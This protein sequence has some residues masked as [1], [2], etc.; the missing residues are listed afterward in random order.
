MELL[1]RTPIERIIRRLERHPTVVVTA[2]TLSLRFAKDYQRV[3]S[4]EIDGA[5]FKRRG[6]T[7]VGSISG[8]MAGAAAGALAGTAFAPGLGTILGAFTGSLVGDEA[9]SRLGRAAVEHAEVRFGRRRRPEA[10]LAREAP[11]SEPADGP[12]RKL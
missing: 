9:G 10:S 3:R 2:A 7:H 12:R 6:W 11:D 5:E 4:G 8:G 1:K